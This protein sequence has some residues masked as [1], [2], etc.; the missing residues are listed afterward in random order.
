MSVVT[1]LKQKLS[2][3]LFAGV[4]YFSVWDALNVEN[5]LFTDTLLPLR[6][7]LKRHLTLL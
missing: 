7:W 5:C 2:D 4:P 3:P 1:Y 6:W